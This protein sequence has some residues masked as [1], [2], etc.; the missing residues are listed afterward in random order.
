MALLPKL[1][2]HAVFEA[3]GT[4]AVPTLTVALSR[5]CVLRV[6]LRHVAGETASAVDG[7]LGIGTLPAGV[8]MFISGAQTTYKVVVQTV[9]NSSLI[10]AEF[11]V[12][13]PSGNTTFTTTATGGAGFATTQTDVAA[14]VVQML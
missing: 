3:I 6:V 8:T 1:H 10:E 2:E 13:A 7:V 9:A 14:Y 4:T 11:F 12:N 5:P